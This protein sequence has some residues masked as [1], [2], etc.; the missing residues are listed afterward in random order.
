MLH[1]A[2]RRLSIRNRDKRRK[3]GKDLAGEIK[4]SK[5]AQEYDTFAVQFTQVGLG[6][7]IYILIYGGF[8]IFIS[9]PGG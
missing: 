2:V 6:F 1:H 7:I 4:I 3:G 8:H 5:G 9:I